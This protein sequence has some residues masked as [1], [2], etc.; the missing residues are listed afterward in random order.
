MVERSPTNDF[1]EHCRARCSRQP[2]GES[3]AKQV[4]FFIEHIVRYAFRHKVLAAI[5]ILSIA[6]G[7]AGFLAIQIAN[8]S[9]TSAFRASVDVV[10]GRANLETGGVIDDALLPVLQKVN[11]VAAATPVV[12]GLVTLADYPGEYLRILGVDPLTN[13]TFEN[14]R[15]DEPDRESSNGGAWF[16]DPTAVAVTSQFAEAHHLSRG[17][18]LRINVNGREARLGLR[19]NLRHRD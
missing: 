4:R 9:A 1:C 17:D 7:V 6:L 15:I 3:R 5:N 18:T 13:G 16:S 8:R 14:S 10:A 19:F 12:E 11:G 2:R